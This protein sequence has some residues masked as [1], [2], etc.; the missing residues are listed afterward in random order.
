MSDTAPI[1]HDN[2]TSS[3]DG[4]GRVHVRRGNDLSDE[5]SHDERRDGFHEEGDAEA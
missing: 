4:S 1:H 5:F 2:D 3:Q